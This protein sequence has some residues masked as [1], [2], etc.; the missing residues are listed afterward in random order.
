M[1]LVRIILF[2][3][4][5]M[6]LVASLE[7]FSIMYVFF[8]LFEFIWGNLFEFIWGNLFEFIWGKLFEFGGVVFFVE[9]IGF[10]V[11]GDFVIID[12]VFYVGR[13]VG[14]IKRD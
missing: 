4:L 2:E 1:S 13:V 5:Y 12:L 14:V 7:V 11:D 8:V 9:Y 6:G 3:E 10:V